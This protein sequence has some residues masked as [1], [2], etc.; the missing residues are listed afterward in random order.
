MTHIPFDF[1]P[2]PGWQA[3]NP[4]EW[5]SHVGRFDSPFDK[6]VRCATKIQ[7]VSQGDKVMPISLRIPPDKEELIRRAA[8]RSGKSKSALGRLGLKLVLDTNI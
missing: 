7:L 1:F 2:V 4:A 5:I 8:Q 3:L 6:T